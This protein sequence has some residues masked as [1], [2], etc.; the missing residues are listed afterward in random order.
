MLG[1]KGEYP[2]T[3]IRVPGMTTIF[4]MYSAAMTATLLGVSVYCFISGI[5]ATGGM[6]ILFSFFSSLMTCSIYAR[7]SQERL[8]REMIQRM[9]RIEVVVVPSLLY[10]EGGVLHE[11]PYAK[12]VPSIPHAQ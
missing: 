3:V 11:I 1:Q 12:P 5:P 6:V 9:S 2:V 4:L 8:Q 7:Y 10:Q